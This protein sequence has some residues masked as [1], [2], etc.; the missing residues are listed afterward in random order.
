MLAGR[1]VVR[2]LR[3]AL[4]K[5]RASAEFREGLDQLGFEPIDEAAEEFPAVIRKETER[6]RALVA[7]LGPQIGR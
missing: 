7:R 1:S 5:A 4:L 6:F 3:A 2:Q